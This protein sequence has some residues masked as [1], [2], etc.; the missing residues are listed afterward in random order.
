M[1]ITSVEKRAVYEAGIAAGAREVY[2]VPSLLASAY[3]V[4]MDITYPFGNTILSIGGG[5]SEMGIMSLGGLVLSDS[6]RVGGANITDQI[7]TYIKKNYQ[8]LIGQSMAESIKLT[9]G[10]AIK[11]EDN[12]QKEIEV[13]GRDAASNMP[14]NIILKTNDV[15]DAVK[16]SLLNII[17]MIK[18]VMERTAPELS[19]DIVDSG[20]IICGG[21]ASLP[22]IATIFTKSIGVSF[23]SA[24]DPGMSVT[25]GLQ[26]IIKDSTLYTIYKS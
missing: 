18:H 9:I 12:E 4:D 22:N 19:S 25:R 21:T 8:L 20:V 23:Y 1:G 16:P 11:V 7:I 14:K 10:N 5:I 15:V 26:K 3:G 6:I 24:D 17:V 13:R 2:L